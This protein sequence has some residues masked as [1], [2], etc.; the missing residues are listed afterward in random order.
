MF[1]QEGN[2]AKF[3]DA[4]EQVTGIRYKLR[5]KGAKAKKA[6]ADPLLDVLKKAQDAGVE[7][8]TEA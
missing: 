2:A 1:K 8:H 6:Q 5:V 7:I 4:A 3:L